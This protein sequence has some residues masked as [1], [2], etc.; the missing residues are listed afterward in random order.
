MSLPQNFASNDEN[1]DQESAMV[2][3]LLC[4]DIIDP[5][6]QLSQS[7]RLAWYALGK[8]PEIARKRHI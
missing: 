6:L 5:A 7:K 1:T 8:V 3:G 2:R 4:S